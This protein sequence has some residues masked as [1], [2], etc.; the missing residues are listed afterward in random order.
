MSRYPG[1]AS[2]P[3]LDFDSY[4]KQDRNATCES[5]TLLPCSSF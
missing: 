1:L 2:R 5:V 3:V 4:T